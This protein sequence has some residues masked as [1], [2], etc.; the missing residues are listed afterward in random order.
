MILQAFAVLITTAVYR[1]GK[2]TGQLP[3]FRVCGRHK[4]AKKPL[5]TRAPYLDPSLPVDDRVADLLSRMTLEEKWRQMGCHEI[6]HM[7]HRGKFSRAKAAKV[8][9]GQPVYRALLFPAA[10]PS[11]RASRP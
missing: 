9:K 6:G 2:N 3:L 1:V 11:S 8:L 5:R 4:M 10:C 7:V